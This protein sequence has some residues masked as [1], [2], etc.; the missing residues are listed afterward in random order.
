M[1]IIGLTGGKPDNRK[2]IAERLEKFGGHRLKT[3]AG[4]ESLKEAPRARDLSLVLNDAG[5]NKSLGGIVIYNVM[6]KAEADDIRRRGGVIWHVMGKPSESI[7][8]ELADPK[9]THMHGGCRHF[10]DSM[11]AFSDHLMQIAAA[12]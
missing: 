12:S 2:E 6:T 7:P 4:S 9:V 5:R 11:H 3:W 10:L 8:M 1:I